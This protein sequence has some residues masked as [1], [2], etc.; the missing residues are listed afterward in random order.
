[1]NE[2]NK[3]KR[4][5]HRTAEVLAGG[6]VLTA[7][8]CSCSEKEA[9]MNQF[10]VQKS[11]AEWRSALTPEQYRILREAGTE[12][13]F[14]GVY[15]DH[16]SP[17]VYRC[18]GCGAELFT[19]ESKFHS[20]CGWPSF[21]SA[22]KE[23]T[24]LLRP[25]LSHGMVRTEAVCATCGGHLGHRFDDGPTATGMRYCINSAALRFEEK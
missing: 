12:R 6:F 14:S 25:D 1:M 23:G 22:A 16:E 3:R 21:D 17:G 7:V 15:T 18:A 13:P 8:L 2:Q 4:I 9:V 5:R 10:P 11:E 20:G 24:V 19:A